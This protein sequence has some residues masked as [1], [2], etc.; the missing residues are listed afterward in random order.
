MLNN[1]VNYTKVCVLDKD[2]NNVT[3]RS[4]KCSVDYVNGISNHFNNGKRKQKN[5]TVSDDKNQNFFVGNSSI[6][7]K[8]KTLLYQTGL[9]S[10]VFFGESGWC[11]LDDNEDNIENTTEND[12]SDKTFKNY[13]KVE[14]TAKKGQYYKGARE[15]KHNSSVKSVSEVMLRETKT[16][17]LFELPSSSVA[18]NDDKSKNTLKKL[19]DY[20]NFLKC[21]PCGEGLVQHAVQTYYIHKKHKQTQTDKV[22][23]M[24][25]DLLSSSWL[26]YDAFNQTETNF[27]EE[28]TKGKHISKCSNE[29]SINILPNILQNMIIMERTLSMKTHGHVVA[30]IKGH[31]QGSSNHF[32]GEVKT[33]GNFSEGSYLQRLFSF[34]SS[35]LQD[36][37]VTCFKWNPCCPDIFVV[38]LSKQTNSESKNGLVC[39]WSF[40]NCKFP[41]RFY[42]TLLGVTCLEFSTK[43]PYLLAV[44][45]HEGIIAIFDVR[46]LGKYQVV[47][48]T[49][50][51]LRP[52]G[53]IWQLQWICKSIGGNEKE[54]LIST[55]D[56]GFILQWMVGTGMEC[57]PL[58]HLKRSASKSSTGKKEKRAEALIS[59][60]SSG[61]TIDF[62]QHDSNIYIVG[63]DE[64]NIHMCSTSYSEQF[65]QTYSFH[66]GAVFQ[67]C[68]SP[69]VPEIFLSASNDWSVCIWEE[70]SQQPGVI[71]KLQSKQ[72][73]LDAKWSPTIS[74][75]FVALSA[76]A[77]E[78]W[79]VSQNLVDPVCSWKSVT[80]EKFTSVCFCKQENTLALGDSTGI[81]TLLSVKGMR[82]PPTDQKK[83]LLNILYSDVSS[84]LL[85][86]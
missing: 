32:L 39:C 73:V 67:T 52:S 77:L 1:C 40:K 11:H 57:I 23:Q 48:N 70:K 60:Y 86:K 4:L 41:E 16:I 33:D 14:K 13:T 15:S 18:I 76:N 80:T 17:W 22:M 66:Q 85:N 26:I 9:K 27:K 7:N 65:L 58:M 64:G 69:F 8:T 49:E 37:S 3:P 5:E 42:K 59:H 82:N 34:S 35:V 75:V 21:H 63:T 50:T 53:A 36:Y 78:L 44:G 84:Q 12:E 29:I 79:D 71:L 72:A 31:K 74:T 51:K 81:V 2:G 10:S 62:K 38:G 24:E 56:D 19:N 45:M 68:W 46:K 55:S 43:H 20:K 28:N 83:A 54:I 6:F 25:K 47:D 30:E 61:F